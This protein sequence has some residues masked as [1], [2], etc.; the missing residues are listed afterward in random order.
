MN[1]ESPLRPPRKY[2]LFAGALEKYYERQ[3]S[4]SKF[5]NGMNLNQLG[6]AMGDAIYRHAG[7]AGFAASNLW[8]VIHGERLFTQLQMAVFCELLEI[9]GNERVQLESVLLQERGHPYDQDFEPILDADHIQYDLET[10][11]LVRRRGDP[12]FS[13]ERANAFEG[14]L[15]LQVKKAST[16]ASR[17]FYLH[18]LGET[19]CLKG[20]ALSEISESSKI[21]T[22]ETTLVEE[23][24]LISKESNDPEYAATADLFLGDAR[25][26]ALHRHSAI[27]YL[28]RASLTLKRPEYQL[29]LNR[30]L[31][32]EYASAG[33]LEHSTQAIKR[34][35]E[36]IQGNENTDLQLVC[37]VLAGIA[38][39]QA[40]LGLFD[41]AFHT[42]Q[43]GKGRYAQLRADRY[44][45]PIAY[46]ELAKAELV[47]IKVS[48]TSEIECVEEVGREGIRL[49]QNRYSRLASQIEQLVYEVLG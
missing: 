46:V 28:K 18:A 31:A 35:F 3:G 32:L 4:Q 20:W 15:R 49:A 25:H 6:L 41:E 27:P 24:A 45:P 36:V 17:K 43:A 47:I 14:W 10:I 42:L 39:A 37:G 19:L 30:L 1:V 34:A 8:R 23:L 16:P 12:L 11:R 29:L 2:E 26:V 13:I 9:R 40:T 7:L 48:K 44:V 33:D 22:D 21:W 38:R 5:R